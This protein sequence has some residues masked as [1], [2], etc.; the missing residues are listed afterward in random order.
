MIAPTF[1]PFPSLPGEHRNAIWDFATRPTNDHGTSD[2][3]VHYFSLFSAFRTHFPI[4]DKYGQN[5]IPPAPERPCHILGA[6]LPP[7]SSPVHSWNVE[8]E[9]TYAIDMGL[10]TACKESRA[11]MLR[12]YRP[13]EWLSTYDETKKSYLDMRWG[14]YTRV[15]PRE[16][17]NCPIGSVTT[18]VT[19]KVITGLITKCL[20]RSSPRPMA[21]NSIS[22]S[23]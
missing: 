12:R 5:V 11:A 6:P 10:W 21:K 15:L 14:T 23:F 22:Q 7:N 4:P 17:P 9:S 18:K 19:T 13:D 1:H 8:N 16:V 20:Q 2:R 3:G